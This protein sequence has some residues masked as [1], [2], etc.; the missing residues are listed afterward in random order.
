MEIAKGM[1]DLTQNIRDSSKDRA[2]D[3]TQIKGETNTLRQEAV[4]MVK[5]FSVTRGETSR[6]LKKDLEQSTTERRKE[7]MQSRKNAQKMT[8][9]L[10][11]SR[12]KSGE[13]LR[14]E[15]A[16]GSKLLVQNEK[17]RKQEVGKML[18]TFQSSRQEINT[19]LKKDLAE[20]KA[21]MQSEVKDTLAAARTLI[22]GF[23]AT[24]Q[25]MGTE[26]K[27]DLEK[28]GDERI[29]AVE[30]MRKGFRQVQKEV[31]AD[32]K[33]AADAWQE[34]GLAKPKKT[35]AHKAAPEIQ[36]ETPVEITPNLVE[37]LLSIINQHP[38][39]ITLSEVAKELGVV[40]IVLGKA[41]KVLL[42]QGKV[43][44]DEKVY[45]P[46]II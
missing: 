29:A 36:A 10:R 6:Q 31:Q 35:S 25:T 40:T 30:G 12:Q 7:V 21:K 32:L 27:Q 15:L 18:D 8:R 46:V 17:K 3:L 22:N 34:L 28:S 26:L 2:E 37:K 19:G 16:Q 20:G 5:D 23:Q 38:E 33:G 44:R 13:Q 45:F 14:K 4:V 24:R 42:E 43:R 9:D 1:Q 39:G 41:A 11:D